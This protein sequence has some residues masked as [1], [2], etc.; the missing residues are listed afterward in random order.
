M[1]AFIDESTEMKLIS[2]RYV[3]FLKELPKG[4][5]GNYVQD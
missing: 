3:S 4:K 5:V 1:I 2:S